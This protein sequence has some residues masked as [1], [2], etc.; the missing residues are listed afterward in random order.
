MCHAHSNICPAGARRTTRRAMRT[1]I[2][3]FDKILRRRGF[4]KNFFKPIVIGEGIYV[5]FVTTIF[6]LPRI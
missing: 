3:D 2:A 4:G 1:E 6:Y 5:F